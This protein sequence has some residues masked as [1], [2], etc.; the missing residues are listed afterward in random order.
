MLQ[1]RDVEATELARLL[2][3]DR[4]VVVTGEAGVGKTALLRAVAPLDG[5]AV[6]EGGALATLS[7]LSYL[8]L[9]RALG[10]DV[11]AGDTTTVAQDVEAAVGPGVLLVDDVQ[12]ADAATLD[13]LLHLAG[14]VGLALGVRRGDPGADPVL[15]RLR[16]AGVHE[17]V[18]LPLATSDAADL[19]RT[20]RPDLPPSAV[21][22]LVERSGGNPLLLHEL[23]ATGEPSASL[24]L[25]L[26]ARLR[27][28][29]VPG[30]EAFGLLA[31][32]GRPVPADRLGD[33]GTKSLLA[34]ELAT[35][36]P[37][38]VQIR[39]ALLAEVAAAEMTE[40]DRRA[41]HAQV[42]RMVGDDAEAARHHHLAGETALAHSAALRAAATAVRPAELASHLA[43]AAATADGP[44]A[45]A[46]RL[47]AARALEQAHD[48]DGMVRVLKLL[49]PGNTEAQAWA[50]L[51]RARGAWAAGDVAGLR[52]ALDAG[53]TLVGGSGSEVEVGLLIERVR[54]PVFV[55]CDLAEGIRQS[56]RALERARTA[57]GDVTRA[58]YLH[59]TALAT[60]DDHTAPRLLAAAIDAARSTGDTSTE[61]LA[62]NNLIAYHES[63]GDPALGRTLCREFLSRA[64]DLGLGEWERGVRVSLVG[65]DFHAGDYRKVI[66]DAEQLL[67]TVVEARGHDQLLEILCIALIDVGRIDEALR[68]VAAVRTVADH[69]GEKQ[70]LW[71]RIEAALW[72]GRPAQALQLADRFL[73]S[74]DDPNVVFG[75]VS[76]AWAATDLGRDPGPPLGPQARPMLH[77]VPHETEGLALLH[78]GRPDAA[79]AAFTTAAR[80]WAP[81][82]RRGELRCLWAAA[83]ATLRAGEVA[84]AVERLEAV[85]QRA[86]EQELL[87]LLGRV[88][89][90]LRAAGQRRSA[91]RTRAAGDTLTGRQREM[92][93][94]VGAG[95]TNAQ[96]AHRLGISRHTVVAQLTSAAAKLGATGRSQA[97]L[98]AAR[99]GA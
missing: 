76:R 39:H 67:D 69:R 47:R 81:W 88:H 6:F 92:L 93:A 74:S 66:A 3:A 54:I 71:V 8:P 63:S 42:A 49:D 15:D 10:R 91:P 80:L 19:V 75:A 61:F 23:T 90:S 38:G 17:L 12:W 52:T 70:V 84:A 95:L 89:R 28:L 44:E 22:R 85:E 24:R 14:R 97:A 16:D 58:L 96:I 78:H 99:G 7:W 57:G 59:G 45:D 21:A 79:A 37:E 33:A 64:H 60:A 11:A 94:L 32:A 18:L 35:I 62:A 20:L 72:G 13:V 41:L 2:S 53:L 27:L 29:D 40:A 65:L 9:Q 68:R 5:R 31:L 86:A 26:A 30:R 36:G 43:L 4:P 48:W 82:H 25:A 98:L 77:A 56:T 34:A 46:L 51:L 1:G 50:C 73:D 87:P 83:E 55:D